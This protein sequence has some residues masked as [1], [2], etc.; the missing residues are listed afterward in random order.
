MPPNIE[1]LIVPPPNLKVAPQPL[2]LKIAFFVILSSF[3]TNTT[4]IK[5]NILVPDFTLFP[6]F[7][8]EQR[9]LC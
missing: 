7:S 5:N 1:S 9:V 8:L 4:Q 3:F 6:K 2:P